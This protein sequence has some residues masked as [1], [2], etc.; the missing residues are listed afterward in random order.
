MSITSEQARE[1][2]QQFRELSV[3]LGN[4]RFDNWG[5]MTAARRRQIESVEWTLLNYSSDFIDTAV[6]ITLD[7][8]ERDFAAIVRATKRARRAIRR[9]EAV[10]DVVKV[11]TALVVLGGA[12]ASQ[13]PGAIVSSARDLVETVG[14]AL[15]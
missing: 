11:A 2:A 10:R 8:T 12:I 6:G 3:Q 1:L 9:I 14:D 5:D 7:D 15:D 13:N 4:Y